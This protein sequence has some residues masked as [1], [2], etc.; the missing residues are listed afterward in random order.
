MRLTTTRNQVE[1]QMLDDVKASNVFKNHKF[2][3]LSKTYTFLRAMANAVYLFIDLTLVDLQKALHPHTAT[4]TDLHEWLKRYG[5]SWKQS[6]KAVHNIRIGSTEELFFPIEIPQ[7]TIV[8]TADAIER[9]RI[10]FQTV[11]NYV[12]PAGITPDSRGHYTIQATVECLTFGEI[13]NVIQD[14]ISLIDDSIDGLDV[15]YNPDEN[16]VSL[17]VERETIT[18]VRSRLANAEAADTSKFTPAWYVAKVEE[19]PNVARAIFRSAREI[20]IP[21]AVKLFVLGRAGDLTPS[22]ILDIQIDLFSDE[23]NPG[24]AA[25][26]YIENFTTIPVNK[27]VRVFFPDLQSIPAQ[28]VLDEIGEKYFIGLGESDDVLDASIRS[29]FFVSIPNVIAVSVE[30]AGDI[31]VDANEVAIAG[32]SWNVIGDVYI[33]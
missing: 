30:P 2:T 24:G 7:G 20:A 23:N 26:V 15:V 18:E 28:S 16:A 1:A 27:T 33:N 10:K 11:S 14:S 8:T 21:G 6:R 4:E 12:I 3:P 31:T 5:L 13:G 29:M 22:E 32:A 17:G 25:Y 9:N 19:H